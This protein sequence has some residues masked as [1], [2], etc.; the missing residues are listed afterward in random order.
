[1]G[2]KGFM[3]ALSSHGGETGA[4]W[5]IRVGANLYWHFS[6]VTSKANPDGD[7]GR[8]K[9]SLPRK[10]PCLVGNTSNLTTKFF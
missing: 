3:L 7:W 8:Q 10:R 4:S 5:G 9:A 1:M 6:S 2:L